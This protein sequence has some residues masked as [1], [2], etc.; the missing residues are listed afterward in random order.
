MTFFISRKWAQI[1]STPQNNRFSYQSKTKNVLKNCKRLEMIHV[2]KMHH[3]FFIEEISKWW[4]M[5]QS[6]KIWLLLKI[7]YVLNPWF[8]MVKHSEIINFFTCI[9][10]SYVVHEI[11]KEFCQNSHFEHMTADFLLRSQN[12]LRR[13]SLEMMHFKAWKKIFFD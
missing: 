4:F 12:S 10:P 5:F 3:I 2:F 1:L 11:I 8:F 9:F 13:N 7:K 6:H